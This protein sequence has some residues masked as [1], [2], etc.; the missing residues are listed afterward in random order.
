MNTWQALQVTHP[1]TESARLGRAE[2]PP[3]VTRA[4]IPGI[5]DSV[6]GSSCIVDHPRLVELIEPLLYAKAGRAEAVALRNQEHAEN[7]RSAIRTA[8]QDAIKMSLGSLSLDWPTNQLAYKTT[9]RLE[10]H[11]HEYGLETAPSMSTVR[12][13]IERLKSCQASTGTKTT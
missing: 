10:A 5:L 1:S 2:E 7:T 11:P 8:T 13:E 3:R 9:L 12:N 6:A 4:E